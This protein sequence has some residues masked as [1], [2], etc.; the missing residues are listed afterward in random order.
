MKQTYTFKCLDRE[1][2]NESDLRIQISK[3]YNNCTELLRDI[4]AY[5]SHNEI[6]QQN[7]STSKPKTIITTAAKQNYTGKRDD[8]DIK[9]FNCHKMGH[10]SQSCSE[11]QRK[12]RCGNCNR[13][14]HK[15]DSC[16]DKLRTS[17]QPNVYKI[18]EADTTRNVI[19]K[20]VMVNNVHTDAFVDPGSN[21]L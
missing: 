16:P 21:R 1:G 4:T 20:Q 18:S 19:I 5:C 14:N 12:E 6:R 8:K 17:S 9:C 11:P 7:Y 10:Y 13:T 15:A 3:N 2:I